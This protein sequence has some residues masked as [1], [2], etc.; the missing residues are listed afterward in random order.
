[1]AMTSVQATTGRPRGSPMS[2]GGPT[3]TTEI[4]S[5]AAA[6]AP[7]TMA[8][9]AKSPPIASTATG[10]CSNSATGRSVTARA[11]SADLYGLTAFVPSAGWAHD[12]RQLRLVALWAQAA[13]RTGKGPVRGPAHAALGLR[14]LP[15]RNC[16][17]CSKR[18]GAQCAPRCS[19]ILADGGPSGG[20]TT[21]RGGYAS[22]PSERKPSS[23]AQRSSFGAAQ[24]HDASLRSMPQLGHRP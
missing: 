17:D 1:M 2:S 15:L 21:R 11:N 5:S 14:G 6:R 4:P 10:S 3:R 7:A 24:L 13:S 22:S 16:H 23:A 18:L 20:T 8:D 9:G 12:V 19:E